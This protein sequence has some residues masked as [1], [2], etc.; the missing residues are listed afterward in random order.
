MVEI[1]SSTSDM[2]LMVET[3]RAGTYAVDLPEGRY[4]VSVAE[5]GRGEKERIAAQVK[6]GTEEEVEL[7]IRASRGQVVPAGPGKRHWQTFGIPD[8][9]PSLLI[10]SIVE[11]REGHLWFGTW[12]GGVS[13]YDGRQDVGETFTNF[14]TQDGLADDW[15]QSILED[16]EGGL[17]FG[18]FGGGVSQY[19]GSVFQHILSRD[20]LAYDGIQEIYP[21]IIDAEWNW[22]TLSW[23]PGITTTPYRR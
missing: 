5:L 1:Q 12:G 15:V 14:T 22:G 8:G 4:D 6:E 10:S 13:R 16:R 7:V 9:L 17:W 11:D 23:S 19:D 18:T 2:A 21:K 3:D 20:G